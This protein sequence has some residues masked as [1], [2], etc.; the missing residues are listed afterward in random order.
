[1]WLRGAIAHGPI[2]LSLSI[3]QKYLEMV[4]LII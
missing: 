4:N 3:L 2:H 1:M